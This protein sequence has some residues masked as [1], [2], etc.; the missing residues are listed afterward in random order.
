MK[1][2][3][4]K[5]TAAT[6]AILAFNAADA[7]AGILTPQDFNLARAS[8]CAA[9]G[10]R[11]GLERALDDSL[12]AGVAP[13][14]LREI[15]VQVY[16]YCGFPRSL[17]AL[18][19]FMNV[20]KARGEYDAFLKTSAESP[21]IDSLKV[22][23]QN[24]TKLVGREVK[25]E[26]FEFA[27]AIDE[28]LK[29]H[30]FGDIFSRP[31]ASWRDRELATIAMLAA[32]YGVER[33]LNAHKA[34]AKNNGLTDEQLAEVVKISEAVKREKSETE[35]AK[36]AADPAQIAQTS[37]FPL[38]SE[39]AA[40]AKFFTGKSYVAPLTKNAALGVPIYNVSFEPAC[41][42]NWHSHTGGQILIAVGG[43][44]LYQEKGKPA[45]L[46]HAGD[47]VEIAPNVVH[48]HG[49]TPD[50]NFS[51]LAVECNPTTNKNT[52]LDPVGDAEYTEAAKSARTSVSD[53]K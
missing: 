18:A 22:G 13:A 7:N 25:N 20:L 6:V 40:F 5:T 4:K 23:A 32:R 21:K 41:R 12:N 31:A 28:Y 47:V 14:E 42:N 51:H 43:A 35:K 1:D 3:L 45:R 52:W 24:Q 50:S 9:I 48:W 17:N 11:S 36:L 37:P 29:A 39:N 30:L 2:I 19:A 8:A 53:E 46:L 10:Y 16:A 15:L 33:Q 34:I 44:G 49:A 38:G 26:I 27:P